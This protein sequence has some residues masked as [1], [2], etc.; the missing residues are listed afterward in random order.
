[1]AYPLIEGPDR[2]TGHRRR[3]APE[4]PLRAPWPACQP[5]EAALTGTRPAS[6]G[7]PARDPD[8]RREVLSLRSTIHLEVAHPSSPKS[9]TSSGLQAEPLGS[10]GPILDGIRPCALVAP[11]AQ[12]N[13]RHAA[14][15]STYWIVGE[16]A[17]RSQP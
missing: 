10:D 11:R 6:S 12:L 17:L 16:R 3:P 8:S 4:S 7:A 15:E 13:L 9:R 5:L 1:V 14:N 2:S